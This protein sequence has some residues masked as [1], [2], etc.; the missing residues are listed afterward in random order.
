MRWA[1]G[2]LTCWVLLGASLVAAKPLP[3]LSAQAP[4]GVLVVPIHGTI[5]LGLAPYVRRALA[6]HP[7]AA[8]VILDVDT[9]GGRVDAAVRI[10]DALLSAGRPS[11]VFVHR[12][13]ISAGALISLAAEHIVVTS[14]ATMGAAT[15]VQLEGGDAKPVEEK[16]VSY[17]RSEMRATAE[18]RGRSGDIAEAMVDA[19]FEVPGLDEKGKLLTLTTDT[20]LSSGIAD[21]QFETLDALLAALGLSEAPR[22]D[23]APTWAEQV[24]RVLTDPTVSGLLMGLGTLGLLIELTH[25]G[26]II[27]GV[28]GALSLG[29]FLGGHWVVELAGWEELILLLLGVFLLAAEL[30]IL[31]GFGLAGI[32]G[33]LSLAAA[34]T[35]ALIGLPLGVSWELGLITDALGV[36]VIST[37]VA[38]VLL[39][40]AMRF[41]PQ[42]RFARGLVLQTTLDAVVTPPASALLG[43]LGVASTDL[44]PAGKALIDGRLV[45]VVSQLHF[46]ERGASVQVVEVEGARVV[47]LERTSQPTHA[48]EQEI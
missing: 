33:L 42:R 48:T 12:R 4:Q 30:L 28:V 5:D 7:D 25:P 38:A 45:D 34:L 17:M 46:V 31:P 39:L 26:L 6:A 9:F 32:G 20:A 41:L 1:V 10:R 15:P 22:L 29:L 18:A 27:P 14:G 35:L 13:A 43:A 24:A 21:A 8:V 16:M 36:V 44:R 23:V 47:V 19:D 2:L 37:F 3:D 40:V 11:I